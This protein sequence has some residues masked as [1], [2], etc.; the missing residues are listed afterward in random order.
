M[1]TYI[2]SIKC[3]DKKYNLSV[4][5]EDVYFS[6]SSK[7]GGTTLKGIRNYNNELRK[8]SDNKAANEF[9]MCMLIKKLY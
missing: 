8:R 1:A 5:G 7:T 2:M 3:G 9:D 6:S 4:S